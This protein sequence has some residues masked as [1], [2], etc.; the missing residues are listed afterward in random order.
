M[1]TLTTFKSISIRARIM[2][3]MRRAK[4]R[5]RPQVILNRKGGGFLTVVRVPGNVFR[6]FQFITTKGIDVTETVYAGLKV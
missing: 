4:V 1:I 2:G 6:C 5:K 3:A